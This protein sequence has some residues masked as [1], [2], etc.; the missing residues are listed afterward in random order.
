MKAVLPILP[1][2]ALL[3]SIIVS[4]AA[5]KI[6]NGDYHLTYRFL[7]GYPTRYLTGSVREIADTTGAVDVRFNPQKFDQIQR[8]RIRNNSDGTAYIQN[9]RTLRY[10]GVGGNCSAPTESICVNS[11]HDTT[12]KGEKWK[13]IESSSQPGRFYIQLARAYKTISRPIIGPW[14]P[15]HR[16]AETAVLNPAFGNTYMSF[17]IIKA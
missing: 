11:L 4:T 15:S 9:V 14:G 5:Q 2:I 16:A 17:Q 3:C 8:W 7:W 10:L 13:I 12:A 1:I 6:P